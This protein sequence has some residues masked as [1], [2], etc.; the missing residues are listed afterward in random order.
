VRLV[1]KGKKARWVK[2]GSVA[3]RVNWDSVDFKV[4]GG[5][6]VIKAKWV[7]RVRRV[8]RVMLATKVRLVTRDRV[9]I[10]GNGAIVDQILFRKAVCLRTWIRKQRMKTGVLKLPKYL[11]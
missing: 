6:V 3:I 9:E 8:R 1:T 2:R 4:A 11:L 5:N 7:R 10:R